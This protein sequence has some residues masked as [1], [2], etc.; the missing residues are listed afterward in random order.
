MRAFPK[1]APAYP[2]TRAIFGGNTTCSP[3]IIYGC[4]AHIGLTPLV[5]IGLSLRES[6]D[7]LYCNGF[8][9]VFRPLGLK[10]ATGPLQGA[11]IHKSISLCSFGGSR[12]L[13]ALPP[14]PPSYTRL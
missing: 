8:G 6:P 1:L 5:I 13:R 3:L 2:Y 9:L 10:R 4:K 7:T 14:K 11:L 12:A